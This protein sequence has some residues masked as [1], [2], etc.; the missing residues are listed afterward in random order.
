MKNNTSNLRTTTSSQNFGVGL[1]LRY[2]LMEELTSTQ[3]SSIDFLEI[4]P[5]NYLNRHGK[6]IL[7]FESLAERYPILVHGLSLS[8]GSTDDINWAYLK[9]LKAFLK[10][11]NIPWFT[12]HLCFSSTNA[13]EFHDLLPLPFTE[14]AALHV[15][16]RARI[17]QDFLEIPF[18]LE[19]VSY[20]L[21][22]AK[23]QMTELEFIKLVL[24]KSGCS[25]LLDVNNLYVNAFNHS[26]DAEHYLQEL[27]KENI[28]Y[29][30]IAGHQHKSKSLIIDTHGEAI[31]DPVWD[32]L[33]QLGTYRSLPSILIERD[34][35][36]PG[37]DSLLNEVELAKN[38]QQI[39][40][41]I[42]EAA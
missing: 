1:G 30:H 10:R 25:L 16:E 6:H 11:F 3:S 20:Y 14:E 40:N 2:A 38:I 34:N 9:Q 12:D 13:H 28:L 15:A 32:L 24:E 26:I 33:R 42:H 17:V 23:P 27:A 37:L 5:E 7:Q 41:Q 31:S 39:S 18:G 22:P 36:I 8:I 19:N 35:N 21:Q 29:I 4:C